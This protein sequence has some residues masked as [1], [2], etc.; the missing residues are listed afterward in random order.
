MDLS[1]R[2]VDSAVPLSDTKMFHKHRLETTMFK[3]DFLCWKSINNCLM[4]PIALS[5]PHCVVN[6]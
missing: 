1:H 3:R 2:S 4:F 6:L 5:D